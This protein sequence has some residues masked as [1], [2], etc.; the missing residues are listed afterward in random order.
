MTDKKKK[1]VI[2]EEL[3]NMTLGELDDKQLEEVAGGGTN[4]YDCQNTS[5]CSGSSNWIS[6]DNTRTC[7][8]SVYDSI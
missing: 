8:A 6:C 1:M 4:I 5:D 2:P 7:L 3:R